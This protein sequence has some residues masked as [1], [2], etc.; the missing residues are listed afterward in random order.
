MTAALFDALAATWVP[1][2]VRRDGPVTLR[3]GGGGGSR[4]SAATWD[5]TEPPDDATVSDA[6]LF[7]VRDGED[8]LDAWLGRLAYRIKDPT[9]LYAGPAAG[10]AG[11]GDVLAHW[12]PL[13]AV[14]ALWETAGIGPAR[15]AAMARVRVPKAA[16][17]ARAGDRIGGAAFVAAAGDVAM[18][19]AL[20]VPAALRRRGLARGILAAAAGWALTAGAGT[21]ALAVTEANAPARAL[22]SG[23][24]LAVAGRYH[25]RV[26]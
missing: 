12:P 8:A 4:L 25:Y 16:L 6:P 11:A 5:G 2:A 7:M 13:A 15:Q 3:D 1:V 17:L 14:R 26:R 19:H 22:Y 9:L 24:G 23:V 21:L 18:L 10:L 20:E